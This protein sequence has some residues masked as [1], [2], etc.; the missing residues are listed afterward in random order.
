VQAARRRHEAAAEVAN[1]KGWLHY[2][3]A[4]GDSKHFLT[5]A[6]PSSLVADNSDGRVPCDD[7][8]EYVKR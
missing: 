8:V 5:F 1:H 6:S 3:P 2:L 4:E 7:P